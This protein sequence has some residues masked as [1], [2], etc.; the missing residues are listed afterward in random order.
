MTGFSSPLGL[1]LLTIPLMTMIPTRA[2]YCSLRPGGCCAGRDDT[3]TAPMADTL[4]YCDEFCL[5]SKDPDCCPDVF[6]NCTALPSTKS[7]LS[8][9]PIAK[10]D[11][12]YQGRN[13]FAGDS[14]KVNC[15]ACTCLPTVGGYQV[16]C[17]ENI[18]LITEE[19]INNVNAEDN[20]WRASNYSFLWGMTLEEGIQRRLGTLKPGRSVSA[21]T[22]VDIEQTTDLP[23]NFDCRQKWPD[24]IEGIMDQGN[25]GS[26]WAVSTTAVASDRLAIQSMGHMRA[27][28]STQNLLSCNTRGQRGCDGGRI[29]RAWFYL[30]RFGIVTDQCYPYQSG[31]DEASKMK[32]YACM[33]PRYQSSPCPSNKM[34]SGKYQS[35][36]PY[37]LSR[38][39]ED[40]MAE[41]L[42]NGPVQATLL[43]KEDFYSYA[44]G[45]YK[46]TRQSV[47]KSS[48]RRRKGYHS[49]RVLG[50]GV[51]RTDP[52]KPRP[53]WLCAN[54]WG[55]QWGENG[56]FRVL[57]GQNEC[58]IESFVLGVWGNVD[59]D[60]MQG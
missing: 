58:E 53:Y 38:K 57:R 43:V 34:T 35:S 49:V 44:G 2:Q 48:K 24:W 13:L 4:C 46:Y 36:P 56:Y 52:E 27:P 28:L 10:A 14:I 59:M 11:C 16:E 21:M 39:E 5:R 30:R 55:S 22:E 60:M 54:S 20:G 47:K 33:L 42:K 32:R 9:N 15:N 6:N 29:D 45:V 23:E 40:I 8:P 19:I 41:I 18:C 50:W 17:E 37:R 3:C 25:C 31:R 7:P 1:L 51:D 12:T 26:S